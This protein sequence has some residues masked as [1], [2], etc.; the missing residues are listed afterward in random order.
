MKRLIDSYPQI[1]D[2]DV[3]NEPI[4]PFKPHIPPS[5]LTKWIKQKAGIY[6]AMVAI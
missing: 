1:N 5:S 3:Y 2:W 6:P 4:G